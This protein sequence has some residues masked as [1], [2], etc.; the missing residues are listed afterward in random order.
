[1][2][3]RTDD[4]L[5]QLREM[6]PFI[7]QS[8]PYKQPDFSQTNERDL[9]IHGDTYDEFDNPI[10]IMANKLYNSMSGFEGNSYQVT[11]DIDDL[12]L[13]TVPSLKHNNHL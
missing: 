13:R 4:K 1:M 8:L 9:K 2:H 12:Q 7:L 6:K 3:V 10:S 11:P 5:D